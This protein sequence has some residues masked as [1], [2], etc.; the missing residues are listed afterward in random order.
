MVIVDQLMQQGVAVLL[1]NLGSL[2]NPVPIL[3]AV[4]AES[5]SVGKVVVLVDQLNELINRHVCRDVC[6]RCWHNP[7]RILRWG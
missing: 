2:F 4:G 7:R 5:L 1:L 3:L 6:R